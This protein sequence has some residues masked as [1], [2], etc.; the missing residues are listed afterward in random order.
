VERSLCLPFYQ[1]IKFYKLKNILMKITFMLSLGI[2]LYSC[3]NKAKDELLVD[4]DGVHVDISVG[5]QTNM[6]YYEIESSPDGKSYISVDKFNASNEVEDL[7]QHILPISVIFKDN[8]K[9]NI[10]IKMVDKDGKFEYYPQSY[11]VNKP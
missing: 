9:A 8:E 5:E 10:R 11:W 2:I 4:Q 6:S 1:I 3:S 7:Y